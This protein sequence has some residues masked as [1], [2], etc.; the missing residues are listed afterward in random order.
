MLSATSRQA[1]QSRAR[2]FKKIG[3]LNVTST[4]ASRSSNKARLLINCRAF[5]SQSQPFE[6]GLF[7]VS[8]LLLIIFFTS[9]RNSVFYFKF[10]KIFAVDASSPWWHTIKFNRPFPRHTIRA[11]N[12]VSPSFCWY[13]CNCATKL[14]QMLNKLPCKTQETIPRVVVSAPKRSDV[15]VSTCA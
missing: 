9:T 10:H 5:S 12:K 1:L 8:T 14:W 13:L 4:V 2:V 6:T 3:V 15:A 7:P 11:A